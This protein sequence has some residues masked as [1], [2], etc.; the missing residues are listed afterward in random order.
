MPTSVIVAGPRTPIGKFSGAFTSLTARDLG[1]TAIKGALGRAGVPP[2]LVDVVQLGQV[3]QAGQGQVTARQAAVRAG[4]P[5][6]VNATTINK[7]CLSSLHAIY[8][9]DLMIRADESEVVVAG[10][11]ESTTNAPYLLLNAGAGY[12]I[13]D[14]QVDD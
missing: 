3:I 11:M 13:S 8:L 1:A 14:Q 4:I 9:A 2:E 6:T 12:R 10:G 5:M 7:A